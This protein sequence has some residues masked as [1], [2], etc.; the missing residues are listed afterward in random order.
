MFTDRTNA[1]PAPSTSS[2]ETLFVTVCLFFPRQTVRQTVK[3]LKF[4]KCQSIFLWP[5]KQKLAI[6]TASQKR[7]HLCQILDR[8][9]K[10][11]HCW[12]AYEIC[13]KTHTALPNSPRHVA[14]LPWKIK[15]SNCL[16]IFS[17]Y[18]QRSKQ[19]AFKCTDFNSYMR[20][21]V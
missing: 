5:A 17:N 4:M 20:V 14:T 10:F 8:F 19:N 1:L 13:Y 9:S 18:E 7:S 15:N 6:N 2:V 21:T 16:Q 3:Q 12:K 11:L